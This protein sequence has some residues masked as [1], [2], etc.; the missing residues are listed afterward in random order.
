MDLQEISL[1]GNNLLELLCALLCTDYFSDLKKLYQIASTKYKNI[2]YQTWNFCDN[3][4]LSYTCNR[5][6][7]TNSWNVVFW[8]QGPQSM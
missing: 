2:V 8:L 3:S 4:F 7:K 1:I 6:T 5:H